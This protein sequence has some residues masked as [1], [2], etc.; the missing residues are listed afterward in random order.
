MNVKDNLEKVRKHLQDNSQKYAAAGLGFVAGAVTATIYLAIKYRGA[1][2]YF[3]SNSPETI[4]PFR[5][6]TG[7]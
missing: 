6:I 4:K 3:I 5:F 7:N 2:L 1:P